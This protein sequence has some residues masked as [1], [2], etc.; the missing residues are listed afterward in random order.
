MA[1]GLTV[2]LGSLADVQRIGKRS[3]AHAAQRLASSR[4][5][6]LLVRGKVER[7][8]EDQVR[9]ENGHA[10]K[11]SKLLASAPASVG[12]PR[13][14]GRGEVRVRGK[15]D[16]AEVNDELDNLEP[17]NPLL[18]PDANTAGALEVVPVHDDVHCQVESNGNP[19]DRGRADELSVAEQSCRAVVVAVEESEGL[20]LEEEEDGVQELEVFGKV[21]E[22]F[23]REGVRS[24]IHGR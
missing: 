12:H 14:V 17:G 1:V 5:A 20:L 19:R 21:V 22:L 3:L 13:P 11:G 18:P 23:K 8:E 7:D 24:N 2:G 4:L 6:S 10:G 16:E 9:R 15:V